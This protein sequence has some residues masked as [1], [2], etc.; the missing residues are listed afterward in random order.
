MR[1][2]D[3][4]SI[5]RR[6]ISRKALLFRWHIET[7]HVC[8]YFAWRWVPAAAKLLEGE[9]LSKNALEVADKGVALL[10]AALAHDGTHSG[11]AHR[12]V[13]AVVLHKHMLHAA[14][15]ALHNVQEA[16]VV[17]TRLALCQGTACDQ[18]AD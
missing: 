11:G 7:V 1:Q 3:A 2:E 18:V 10:V 17:H 15:G 4:G 12:G 16:G 8:G 14:H 6:A 5:T 9:L 13:H